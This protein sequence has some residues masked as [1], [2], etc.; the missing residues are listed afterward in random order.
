MKNASLET[1]SSDIEATEIDG[2]SKPVEHLVSEVRQFYKI[3]ETEK[4]RFLARGL[5]E[6]FLTIGYALSDFLEKSET[7]WLSNRFGSPEVVAL[8]KEN[9]PEA[10]K[11]R[12]HLE[13]DIDLA[14]MDNEEAQHSLKVIKKGEGDEDMLLDIPKLVSLGRKHIDEVILSGVTE[15][16]LTA[17]ETKGQQFT[18]LFSSAEIAADATRKMKRIRDKAKTFT[19]SYLSLI[20]RYADAI[21]RDEPEKRELFVSEYES[22]RNAEYRRKKKAEAASAAADA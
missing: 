10:Y 16:D 13:Q 5:K 9:S 7:D 4:P 11:L 15:E 12:D 1:L 21:Y 20:R 2:T 17:I 6:P 3:M 14:L 22:E 19:N 8:W 18:S